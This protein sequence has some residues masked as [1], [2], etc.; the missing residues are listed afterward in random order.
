M[1]TSILKRTAL[2][3]VALAALSTAAFA[4]L[5]L[6]IMAPAAPGGGW[7]GTARSMQQALTAA[8][9]AK[10]VQVTNVTGAGGTIGLA[11]LIG[12]KGDG[13][14]LMVN[15]FVMVGAI[16]LNKSPVNLSQTTPIARLTAEALVIV[17]PADS[18]IKNAKDLAE[19]VKADPAKVTWAG[20]SAGGA[21]HI[22][23]ALFAEAAGGDAKKINYIPFSGG[24]EALAAMLGGRV[25][26]GISGYGEFEGQI[27]AGK[28]RVVGVS[29]SARLANA[30][31]APTL[32]EGGVNLELMNWRSVVA[33]PGLSAEQTKTLS[34]AISKMVKSK[35]WAEILKARGWDDAYLGGAEFEAFMKAEQARVAKVMT[36]VG[37]VK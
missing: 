11:Q 3:A 4:Q 25:T 7:D 12:A 9:I 23:A 20:G 35:E 26:A 36:D 29:S 8:G 2:T 19:R 33:P 28:L 5:E 32:K 21:D 14:Q 6:K 13:H 24:G 18:P 31:D 27:K 10:S 34:D 17:V 37:L 22:L 1:L 30:P 16:L 15:G